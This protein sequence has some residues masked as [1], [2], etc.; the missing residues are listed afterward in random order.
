MENRIKL[1]NSSIE[2][3]PNGEVI[4]A[5]TL[6]MGSLALLRADEYQREVLAKTGVGGVKV[7][8][9]R[10]AIEAGKRLPPIELGMR[11]ENFDAH[12]KTVYLNDPVFIVD[13]L[14]RVSTML[15]YIEA[16]EGKPNGALPIRAEVYINSTKQRESERF[17]DLNGSRTPVSP[18]VLLRNDRAAHPGIL[19]IYGLCHKDTE[20]ALH[21][22]VCWDQ[23]MKQH[24]LISAMSLAKTAIAL[25]RHVLTPDSPHSMRA[26]SIMG[27][28][29]AGIG[30]DKIAKGI[31]L[32]N[33]RENV[34]DFFDIIERCWS[35]RA[36]EY[37]EAQG[38][39][40]S[41]FL[42]TLA[43]FLVRNPRLWKEEAQHRLHIDSKTLARLKQFNV[44]E[45][46]IRRLAAAGTSV[47][48]TLYDHLR[49]HM[50]HRRS[51]AHHF[52]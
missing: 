28:R 12:G 51:K 35:I 24:E 8:K 21:G 5:G 16:H 14:Q 3:S 25:H 30:L 15:A 13:G 20:F 7:S 34:K 42:V 29:G 45:P 23:R 47:L 41:N 17:S 2:E 9:I 22:R 19:T 40:R 11:G 31:S 10:K 46:E 4:L 1:L 50:N 44:N 36:I 52:I 33:F 32:Q 38:H 37:G 26:P 39:L 6:D 43:N 27:V 48:P 49:E 18:N